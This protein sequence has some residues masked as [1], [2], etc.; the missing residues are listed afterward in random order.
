MMFGSKRLIKKLLLISG[1]A[2]L[3]ILGIITTGIPPTVAC[4]MFGCFL[5][6]RAA[7][8]N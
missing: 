3:I 4:I 2:A 5:I 1:G 6:L 8:S 7:H